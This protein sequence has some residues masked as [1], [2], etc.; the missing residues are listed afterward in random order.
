MARLQSERAVVWLMTAVQF[1]NILDFMMVMPLGPDF[2]VSLGIPPS[3]LGLV[4]GSYT[5]AAA[6]SGLLAASFLDR[7]DR[8]SA[9][10]G[11]LSGLGLTTL[12][13]GLATDLPTLVAARIGAGA[14]GGP[15]TALSLSIVADIVPVERR[16]RAMGVVMGAFAIASVLGVPL[17]LEL[18][19]L[20][21]W[22]L[23]FWAVGTATLVMMGIAARLLPPMRA[24]LV[25]GPDAA[26][27]GYGFLRRPTVWMMLL[28]V[29]TAYGANF[30]LI[31]NLATFLQF[32]LGFPREQLG[33][34]YMVGGVLSFFGMRLAGRWVDR[35]G[36][37]QV[38]LLGTTALGMVI[39]IAF[40]PHGGPVPVVPVFAAF[41]VTST[42]RSVAMNT[43]AS[44]V[45]AASER[46]RYMSVQSALGHAASATGAMVSAR[47]LT[48][49][50][51]LALVG[52]DRL[53]MGSLVAMSAMGLM[54]W[55]E[56][57][58]GR[59]SGSQTT[60][61]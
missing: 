27:A 26:R 11:A 48:E 42:F 18:A 28:V 40:L 8:R 47:V 10:L 23:P 5:G 1:V 34:L 51:D 53:A 15:A 30:A 54:F 39:A 32:N 21:D 33:M 13:G 14:F 17:G 7:L 22:R 44:R 46:A 60:A 52:M 35:W 29:S 58:L 55:I 45:P 56:A 9:L 16:G 4:G 20:W 38:G 24:H 31:P 2:A 43:L 49:D 57:R 3:Q 25:R 59:E 61:L 37:P 50:A 6:V 19:R 36:A 12:A 41:M